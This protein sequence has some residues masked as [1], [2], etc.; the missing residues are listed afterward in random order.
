MQR[1]EIR[2]LTAPEMAAVALVHRAAFDERLPW[3]AGLHTPTEDRAYFA[4]PVYSSCIVMGAFMDDLAGFIA[5]REGWIDQ[6]YVRPDCQ[7]RG[8]GSA[9]VRHAIAGQSRVQLW[10]FVRNTGARQFYERHGFV[11]GEETDGGR[12]EER[13][14]DMMYEWQ[15]DPPHDA[16]RG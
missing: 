15:C 7:R 10:T 8:I 3:L 13:E 12:N 14:P 11:A 2:R 4:G 1:I 9:L 5:W 16:R 6:L